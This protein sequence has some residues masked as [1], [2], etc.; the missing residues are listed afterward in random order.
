[1]QASLRGTINKQSSRPTCRQV[2][3]LPAQ[4]E[5]TLDRLP[6]HHR[7][8]RNW[9]R[10]Q[11]ARDCNRKYPL[12]VASPKGKSDRKLLCSWNNSCLCHTH[13]QRAYS[14]I[15]NNNSVTAW[16]KP[17]LFMSTLPT[18]KEMLNVWLLGRSAG[19]SQCGPGWL[20]SCTNRLG[21]VLLEWRHCDGR[22][23]SAAALSPR[24]KRLWMLSAPC[25][26]DSMCMYIFYLTRGPSL[27]NLVVSVSG[28]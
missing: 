10:E 4:G 7:C 28:C 22:N 13:M 16:W 24:A 20:I 15:L 5:E 25:L 8:Y 9:P 2:T 14:V 6:A 12:C 19:W 1:M 21:F 26:S 18:R 11:A 27:I 17:G 3:C 23:T